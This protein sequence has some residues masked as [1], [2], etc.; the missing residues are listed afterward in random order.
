MNNPNSKMIFEY[1]GR[2]YRL[3]FRYSFS[4]P[5]VTT[6]CEV[7]D[8]TDRPPEAVFI[9]ETYLSK[10]DRFVKYVGRDIALGRALMASSDNEFRLAARKCYNDRQKRK[11]EL[12]SQNA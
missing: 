2:S 11:R 1:N 10:K 6:T 3:S 8:M 9:G 12:A 7:L 4:T 5:Q